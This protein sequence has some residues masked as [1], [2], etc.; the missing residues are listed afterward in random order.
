MARLLTPPGPRSSSPST[1]SSSGDRLIV[2]ERRDG[3]GRR[4]G[5]R[6]AR[7]SSTSGASAGL[8][9]ISR[10]RPGDAVLAGSTV[11]AGSFQVEVAGLGER[12]RAAVDPP[13]PGRRDEPRARPV[14]P[15]DPLRGVRL[16]G[17]RPDPGDGG[18]RPPGRR[19]HDR[20]RDPPARLRDR[21]RPGRPARDAP[22]RR[23]LRPAGDRRPRPRGPRAAGRG[24]PD[25]PRRPPGPRPDRAGGDPGRDPAARADPAPLR[26]QRLP[27][28]GRRPGDG[29]GRRLPGAA[30]PPPRPRA[31]STSAGA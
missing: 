30:G 2:A 13:G 23:P 14:G 28:P 25:R 8:E 31:P 1:G 21:P 22:Q 20:R 4:P 19:P 29:P 18:R 15:D 24:R 10:K 3:P 7:A 5:R 6:R 9:G 11:L 12:T 17:R 26:R 27:P 16:E